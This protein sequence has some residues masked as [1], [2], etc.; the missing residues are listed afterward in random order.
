MTDAIQTPLL[1]LTGVTKTYQSGSK[2][3][4]VLRHIDLEVQEAELLAIIGRSGSGKTTLLNCI[5]GLDKVDEGSITLNGKELVGLNAAG[6]DTVRRDEIGFVFQFNNLLP[7]FS[8]LENVML[9]GMLR[10][11]QRRELEEK[12]RSL[13]SLMD[14]SERETHLP[15][16]LSGGE[17]Q[18]VAIARALINT[19]KLLLADEP[20]GSLDLESG[21][22]VF[23]LLRQL[24]KDLKIS[25]LVVTHNPALADLCAR[26]HKLE[27]SGPQPNEA[28]SGAGAGYV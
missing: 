26:I 22:K 11:G 25:C 2:R 28:D 14:M 20:T 9:P 19:P 7:E 4:H 18:R 6:W 3:L 16:Q 23:D 15:T 8:A 13:L 1:K 5:A 10:G 24:Q 17:Q 21:Q 12:A 27:K